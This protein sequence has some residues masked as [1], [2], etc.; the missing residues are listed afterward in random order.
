MQLLDFHIHSNCSPDAFDTMA[1][2]ALASGKAG[3]GI[4]CFTDHCDLDWFETGK[5]DPNCFDYW[6]RAKQQLAEARAI[7]APEMPEIRIGIELGET[8]HD[9][10][11][12]AAIA[13]TPEFDFVIGTLHSL[14]DTPDFYGLDYQ[15]YEQCDELMHRYFAE[16]AEIARIPYID[17]IAHI[18]YTRRYM[19]KAGFDVRADM[20]SYGD[21][22]TNVLQTAIDHGRGI[23]INTSGLR[24]ADV[25]Q[26]IPGLD[27]LRRYRELGG[28]IITIGSDAHCTADA[29]GKLREGMELLREAGFKY[30]TAFKNRKPE[31]IKID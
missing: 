30:V 22:I 20:A 8:N 18:G 5:P 27:V 14:R 26:S 23:E 1:D 6:S 31:F 19:K 15:S 11:R 2:M 24:N 9:P 3:V 10:E 17:V 16:L 28:E 7:K 25:G 21:E 29:G 4:M 13:A 12:G